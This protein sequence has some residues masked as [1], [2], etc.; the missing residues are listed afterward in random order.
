MIEEVK[1]VVWYENY[2]GEIKSVSQVVEKRKGDTSEKIAREIA[3]DGFRF[4]TKERGIFRY[5]PGARILSIT[6]LE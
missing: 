5:I 3:R 4:Q 1:I 2:E 6:Y